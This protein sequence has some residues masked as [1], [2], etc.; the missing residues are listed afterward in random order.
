MRLGVT[1]CEDIWNDKEFWKEHRYY[2]EDPLEQLSQHKV[3]AV[4]NLSASPFALG[5][6]V[7]REAMLSKIA[8][9]YGFG[10]LY[11]NQVGG[12]D[13]LLFDGR[14]MAFSP[15]GELR[16]RA[17][18]FEEEV[19]MV[20]L[21]NWSGKIAHDDEN[22]QSQ[23]WRALTLGLR[24]Y[25]HKCGFSK[26][27]LG[28]SGGIDSSLTAAIAVEA[29]GPDNVTG[30]LMPSPYSSKGSITDSLALARKPRY[31]YVHAEH[32]RADENLR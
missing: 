13:D 30:V 23:A 28:L 21:E 9:K 2:S 18:G 20:D 27:V 4:I 5:K 29:L 15:S 32:R 22:P 26:A 10:M 25:T 14:S 8:A 16:A 31:S 3:D 7:V 1:I 11:T 19:L 17:Q 24:D 6:R 12:N